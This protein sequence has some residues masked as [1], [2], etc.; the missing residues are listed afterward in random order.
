ME[1]QIEEAF[2]RKVNLPS[3][4]YI[5]LDET[6]A[7][8][9]VDVN[10]GRHKGKGGGS[11]ER[12]IY[13][14][15]TEAVVEVARQL[16]LRNIGGLVVIDL[17]DMRQKRHQNSVYRALKAELKRDKARTNVLQISDLGLLEMTRQRVEESVL[18]TRY[19]DCPYCHG[20]GE[21]KSSLTMSV[22]VQ[23]QVAAIMRRQRATSGPL[24]VQVIVHPSVLERLRRED[25]TALID[26]QTEYK[27]QL[28]FRPD[29]NRHV[30]GF[31]V[32]NGDTGDVL[33][34][35]MER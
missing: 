12:A 1:R 11:Q 25:E 33:Y 35:T 20:R 5:I 19:V 10:T 30:E 14:V 17:I 7:M 24:H 13:E 31:A 27:G 23:R 29:P 32:K 34:A 16:R 2:R 28:S 21:V 6:E 4:G 8:I 3:G 15:N 22:E 18:S 9:A 26:L